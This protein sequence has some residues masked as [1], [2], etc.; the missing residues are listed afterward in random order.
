MRKEHPVIQVVTPDGLLAWLITRY[1]DVLNALKDRRLSK[2]KANLGEKPPWVPKYFEPLA[3]NMLDVDDPDHA[4]LRTLVHK[5]F[6]PK[7]I[8]TLRAS[9]ET[10]AEELI[11]AA[12]PRGRMDLIAE[13][14]L[15]LPVAVISQMLGIPK[16]E[17]DKF[18][19]WSNAIVSSQSSKFGAL[20]AIPS[21]VSFLRYI[22]R[23]VRL[24]Q[25]HPENDLTTAMIQAEE[26][27]DRMNAYEMLA[28]IFLLLIAGHETTVNLIGNGML[29]LFAHPEQMGRL[30]ADASLIAP[31]VEEMLRFDSPLEMA[32]ERYAAEE[33]E[34]SGT[35]IPAG[36]RVYAVI[37]SANRDEQQ[38]ER[39]DQ[40]D[41][42][43]LNNRHLSFGMGAHYC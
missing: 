34:L 14:A 4:R 11:E 35:S 19:S 15:P 43:R 28:M 13:F 29:A 33:V 20:K 10:L 9:I 38:F 12:E 16:R 41:L 26:A 39:A 17:Q 37:A 23:L 6:T 5:A 36:A 25:A 30:R 27:G 40:F 8:E 1:D 42:T 2:D 31:A 21:V 24:R 7:L 18:H 3:R 22:R 32:S